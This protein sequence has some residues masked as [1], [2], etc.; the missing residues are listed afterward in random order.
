MADLKQGI[1]KLLEKNTRF[2]ERKADSYRKVEIIYDISKNA[3][4]SAKVKI[5]DTEVLAG[6]KMEMIKPYPDTPD[7]GTISVNVELTPMANP[8]FESG[9][10]GI[11]AIEIARVVDRGIRESK[12]IDFKKL[13][14]E[15]G[16]K[17][18]VV[19]IDIVPINDAGNLFD[20]AALAAIA[21]VKDAKFPEVVDDKIDYKHKTNKSLPVTKTPVEVTVLKIGK[22][23]VVDPTLEEQSVLD[24]RLS[25][26][27]TE[28]G[29]FAALQKGGDMELT[30]EEVEQ[31]LDLA[32]EKSKELRKFL[33]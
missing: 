17:V 23:Y 2:D 16:E 8:N 26:A 12:C 10:P 33:K 15:E 4:G 9:P 32:A 14:V 30:L 3:E 28:D 11:E 29:K 1:I 5:G 24:A 25:V 6:V 7:E 20:A 27:T 13:C 18:W 19:N 31:M 21:A 22:F